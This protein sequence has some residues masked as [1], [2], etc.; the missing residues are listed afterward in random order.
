V[1]QN[2]SQSS[3]FEGIR[4]I[5]YGTLAAVL[6]VVVTLFRFWYCTQLELVGDEAYY[7]NCSRHLDLSYF[8][9][10]PG[11][12]CTI[13][14]GTKLFGD[15]VFGVRFRGHVVRRDRHRAVR[16]GENAFSA[17]WL[18]TLILALVV[19]R[20]PSA[21]FSDD[22]PA[23]RL[24]WTAARSIL[25]SRDR[26]TGCLDGVR[27]AGGIGALA[28]YTNL[29]ELLCFAVFCASCPDYRKH[30]RRPYF[31][32]LLASTL[33]FAL[34]IILWNYRH[35]WIA[36]EHL[37][38]RGAI[39]SQWRFNPVELLTFLGQQAGVISPLIFLGIMLVVFWPRLSESSPVET[40]YLLSLFLPLFLLYSF[41][42]LNKAGQPNWTA[43]SY[44]AGMILLVAKWRI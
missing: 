24:L 40:R 38:H 21:A 26:G 23:E 10:G 32:T 31:Y 43:P 41:L 27:R 13:A 12:A 39:N 36:V 22:R 19:P 14:L 34:P 28:K 44:V 5:R 8:D 9:K 37:L 17:Q 18:R 16:A 6:L 11:A 29:M 3:A 35:D 33:I 25:E 42:S 15:T 30:F 7:W 20:L 2:L 4:S 1:T